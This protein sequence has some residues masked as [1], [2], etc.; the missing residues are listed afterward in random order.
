V[1]WCT[2]LIPALG[3]SRQISEFKTSQIYMVYTPNKVPPYPIPPEKCKKRQLTERGG[4]KSSLVMEIKP[5]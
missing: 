2:P 5:K 3:R 4:K 1:W